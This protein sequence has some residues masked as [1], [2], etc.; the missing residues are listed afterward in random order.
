MLSATNPRVLS[1]LSCNM[2]YLSRFLILTSV[3]TQPSRTFQTSS[4]K[5]FSFCCFS[6]WNSSECLFLYTVI[7][8]ALTLVMGQRYLLTQKVMPAGLVAG[9]RWTFPLFSFPLCENIWLLY[10]SLF[11]SSKIWYF[12]FLL[13][14]LF[15]SRVQYLYCSAL[16]T[17]FYVYKI[18]TGG[19]KIS[20]KTEWWLCN[21]VFS[22]F[23]HG[24]IWFSPLLNLWIKSLLCGSEISLYLLKNFI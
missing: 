24:C 6:D 7:S 20:S 23:S 22:F 8:A 13:H 12:A 4:H 2:L 15:N 14:L 5:L 17:C 10:L 21:S 9:I 11:V 19:N 1:Y 16:M 18:A 3:L